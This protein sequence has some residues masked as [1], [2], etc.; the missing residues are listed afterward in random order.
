[1]DP[2][3]NVAPHTAALLVVVGLTFILAAAA[4]WWDG[5]NNRGRNERN[6]S[7]RQAG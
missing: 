2:I 4:D 6:E 1:M 5:R 7:R 3:A